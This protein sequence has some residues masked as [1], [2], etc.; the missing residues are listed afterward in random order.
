MVT[1]QPACSQ[2]EGKGDEERE[3]QKA[4]EEGQG[5]RE[6]DIRTTTAEQRK[7]NTK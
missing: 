3:K 5:T 7:T 1:L 2:T 6:F 4:S